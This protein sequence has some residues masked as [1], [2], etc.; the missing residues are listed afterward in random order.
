MTTSPV[1]ICSA[2]VQVGPLFA[3]PFHVGSEH[4]HSLCLVGEVVG[5]LE[6]VEAQM[7]HT[8]I[9][10]STGERFV[11]ESRHVTLPHARSCK[12]VH[13]QEERVIRKP[14]EHWRDELMEANEVKLEPQ[15]LR[16]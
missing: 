2:V 15:P 7:P 16:T 3:P 13:G 12:R 9:A 1:R 4:E 8:T 6:S 14:I 10:V 11:D 5:E